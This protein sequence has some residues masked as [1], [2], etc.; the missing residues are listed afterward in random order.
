MIDDM[1]FFY[2][3]SLQYASRFTGENKCPY[4]SIDFSFRFI[5]CTYDVNERT[6][7]LLK[8]CPVMHECTFQC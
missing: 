3:Y 6:K 4:Y 1:L 8:F 5:E 7:T 2:L